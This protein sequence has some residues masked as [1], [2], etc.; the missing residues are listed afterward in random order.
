[1]FRTLLFCLTGFALLLVSGAACAEVPGG[2]ANAAFMRL[3][4]EF[5]DHYYFPTNPT[6]ATLSGIHDYDTRLED[7]SRAAIDRQIATLKDYLHRVEA[8]DVKTLDEQTRGDRELVLNYIRGTLLT[9]ETIKPWQKN[10]DTYSSGITNSAFS[11][12]ERKFASPED[13]LRDLIA[14][15]KLMPGVLQQARAN[16]AHPPKIYTQ[17]ALQQLP[18]STD[19]FA[20]DVPAAFSEVKGKALNDAFAR[21]NAAVVK[22]LKNYRA[23]LKKTLLAQSDGDFRLGAETYRKKLAFDEM[24]DTPLDRLLEIDT[25]NMRR[26]QAEFARVAKELEPGKSAKEVLAEMAADHPAPDK[27]LETFKGTFDGLIAFINNRHIITIPSE[28]RP[29]LEETPPFM[30]AITFASMDTPGPYETVAKEAYFNVTLPEAAWDRKHVD[31]FMAQFSYPVISAIAT[32]EA[33]P[34]HYVQF[35]WMQNVHDRV[36]RLLGCSSNAEGWAHYSEQMMLDEGLAQAV[37][38]NDARQQKLLRLGQLQDALL[39]NARFIVGIKLHTGAFTFDQ[40][41]DF[42]V[43]EGYQ[44]RAV[45]D[46]ETKRGTADPTYLYYTLGKLQILKLRADLEARQ[47]KAFNLQ[48]FHDAFM[49]QGFAPIR[50]VRRAM[51]GDESPTL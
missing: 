6:T 8:V 46:V 3:A 27:L 32:H 16:L 13:R 51:L 21:A 49:Q 29:I 28:V 7:F 10:P 12:L 23:W 26:N 17:I 9:L 18:G 15:E 42:F 43:N 37:Y 14:R 11:I 40:G 19:F 24:V 25:E 2:D 22:A 1:M 39:R 5:F 48:Q 4:D 31:E 35:L 38:P 45:G 33:Y 36:R 47:G 30:R 34:G 20:R 41:V 50:I 44:S